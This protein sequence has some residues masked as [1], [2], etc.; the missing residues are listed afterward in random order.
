MVRNQ[1][2]DYTLKTNKKEKEC[3]VL[4]VLFLFVYRVN[5]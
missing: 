1:W 4:D 2:E 3:V 5:R